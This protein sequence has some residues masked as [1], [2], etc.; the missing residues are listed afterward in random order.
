MPRSTSI[1]SATGALA[2]AA[3]LTTAA[4]AA[5]CASSASAGGN[6]T[7]DTPTSSTP[8]TSTPTTST[9]TTSTDAASDPAGSTNTLTVVAHTNGDRMAFAVSGSPHAGLVTI[10]FHNASDIAHEL[11]Y[12]QLKPGVT[13]PQ[14]TKALAGS[15]PEQAAQKLLVAP[16]AETTGPAIAGPGVTESVTTRI[17]AGHYVVTCFLPGKNGMPHAMMGMVAEFTVSGSSPAGPPPSDGTVTLTDH[18]ITLPDG[19]AAGGT[20]AVANTGTKPH[21][22]SLARLSGASLPALF[23]CIGGSFGKGT[24][25]DRCPGTLAGG[26]SYLA[27]DQTAYLTIHPAPGHYGYVST[28]GNGADF[29]AGLA[30]TFT[31]N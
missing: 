22:L 2:L 6:A 9:P 18:G 28:A 30:G 14:V 7:S 26:V 29:K 31:I 23:Q 24:P 15:G 25:I 1:R 19:F 5:G 16:H 10:T 13:L 17:V 3:A 12:Q 4:L 8:T 11:G 20:F 27:P 21:D